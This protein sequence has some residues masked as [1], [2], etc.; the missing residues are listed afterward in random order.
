M[1][2]I[3]LRRKLGGASKDQI[4]NQYIDKLPDGQYIKDLKQLSEILIYIYSKGMD[5]KKFSANKTKK[6]K[7]NRPWHNDECKEVTRQ[8][9]RALRASGH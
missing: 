9:R 7:H 2:K 4:K 3:Y 6:A 1:K 5:S 8:R